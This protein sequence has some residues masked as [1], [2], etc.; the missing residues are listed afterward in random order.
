M[1]IDELPCRLSFNVD[2]CRLG[3][4]NLSNIQSNPK[5][6]G[7][8]PIVKDSREAMRIEACPEAYAQVRENQLVIKRANYT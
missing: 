8:R 2:G 6:L 7:L 5:L 3:G 1:D 4:E